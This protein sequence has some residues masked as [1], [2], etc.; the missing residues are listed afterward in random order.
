MVQ[1]VPGREFERI[2]QTFFKEKEGLDL[3]LSMVLQVGL[4]DQK[5]IID[6]T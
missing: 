4:G 6:S 5:R 1:A 3:T 2:V